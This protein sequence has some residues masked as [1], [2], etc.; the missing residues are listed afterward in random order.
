MKKAVSIT[1]S[2][3]LLV[4]LTACGGNEKNDDPNLGLYECTAVELMGISMA[5]E[6]LMSGETSL[7]LKAGGKGTAIMDGSKASL[8]WEL[9][10]T[11]LS[12]TFEGETFTGTLENGVIKAEMMGMTM[13]FVNADYNPATTGDANASGKGGYFKLESGTED[14]ETLSGDELRALGLNYYVVLNED[15]T[16]VFQLDNTM[17]G[18]WKDGMMS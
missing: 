13:T 1:L 16:A 18:T 5:P 2:L 12:F 4:S 9:D 6:D 3:I 7:E 10:G 8:K 17:T 14:G 11:A 15:G